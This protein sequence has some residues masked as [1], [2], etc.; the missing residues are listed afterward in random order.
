MLADIRYAFRSF[1][2]TPGFTAIVLLTTALGIGA[3]TAIFTVVNAVL[4]RPFPYDDPD[5]LVRVRAGSSYMDMQDWMQQAQSFSAAGGFRPQLFDYS[6]AQEAERLDGALVTGTALPLFGARTLMGRLIAPSDDVVG[7][8]P[9][10]LI[11]AQLWRSRLG[12][13]PATIGRQLTFNGTSYTIIGILDPGFSLPAM[14]ADVFAPFLPAAGRE[15]TARG[16]HTLRAFLRLKPGVS[17]QQGQQEMDAIAVRLEQEYPETNHQMRFSL[18]PLADSV[19]GSIRPALMILLATVGLVL[20]I[21]CVNV[22]NLLIARGAARRGEFAVKAAIGASRGR[23]TRQLLTESLLLAVA[24]GALALVVAY[25]LTQAIVNLAP[26]DVPRLD[27]IT[28][29]LRVLGFTALLSVITGV[30]FG[31]LPAWTGASVSLADASRASGRSTGSGTARGALLVVEFALALVLVVGAG[32]LLR[33]FMALTSKEPGFDTRGLVTAN[34]TL[35]AERYGNVQARTQLFDQLEE[36]LQSL[37]GVRSVA[38][39][40]DLPIGG[41]PIFHNLAF[42]GRPVPAGSEPE[43]YYRGVSPG[44]FRALGISLLDG[45]P[46]STQDRQGSPLVAIVNQSFVREYYPGEDALGRRIRWASGDGEW[47]TIVGIVADV[48]AL[49]LEQSEVPAVHVPYAQEQMPWRRWMDL[50]VRTEGDPLALTAALRAELARIDR[51]VPLARVRSMDQVISAS[52]ADRTFNL[53]LLGGFALLALTLA[54]A[55]T[56]GVMS[57]TVVQRTRELG[58]RMALGARRWDV[59]R[60]VVGRGMALASVGI[61]IGA[62]AALVL[63]RAIADMLFEVTATDP[64]TLMV[65]ALVLL[66]SAAA[67]SFIPARR[68]MRVDPLIALRSE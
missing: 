2:K 11:S 28:L 45:R 36:R 52:V 1:L 46:F 39:T 7:A 56:Y 37:P 6:G 22:A 16:A 53:F 24:G 59:L 29:D 61:V 25:W 17:I 20:L 63:S 48:R 60:L 4:L 30:V 5:S 12:A 65:A 10:A 31:V 13:D 9:V 26:A 23:L 32:L 47:I 19:V 43:V 21:A 42:E 3:N 55:G 34:I 41:Q 35:S 50:A 49:S 68:A 66:A 67:A 54:A 18:L 15:A 57:Y 8:E 44:Y 58:V 62:I 27:S 64:L 40:T 38:F 33:S 51:T 14:E